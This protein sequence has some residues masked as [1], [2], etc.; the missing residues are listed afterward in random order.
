[1]FGVL[2]SFQMSPDLVFLDDRT[3]VLKANEDTAH[4]RD[5]V[6]RSRLFDGACGF[7]IAP[8][9]CFLAAAQH[10]AATRAIGQDFHLQ[11]C[12]DLEIL[13]VMVCFQGGWKLTKFSL[14]KAMFRLRLLRWT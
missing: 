13:G 5:A 7:Q 12:L 4:L 1:M 6:E 11:C 2:T 9:K 14:R 10:D 8:D 3:L